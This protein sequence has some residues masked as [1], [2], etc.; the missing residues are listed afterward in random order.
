VEIEINQGL[1][2]TRGWRSFQERIA[3]SLGELIFSN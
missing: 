2:G 1:V 3:T